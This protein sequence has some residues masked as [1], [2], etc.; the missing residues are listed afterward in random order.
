MKRI[1]ALFLVLFI[2]LAV[3]AHADIIP[4]DMKPIYV[5]AHI[6]N[7]DDYPDYVFVQFES[8]GDEM[9]GAKEIKSSRGIVPGYKLS[10]L[11]VLAVPR[12]LFE[13]QGGIAGLNLMDDSRI[14][15]SGPTGIRGQELVERNSSL[16]GRDVFYRVSVDN[17]GVSLKQTG[18][19]EFFE[20]PNS[21]AVDLMFY[22]LVITFS[23]ELIVFILLMRIGFRSRV[24]AVGRILFAVLAAQLATLP[25]LWLIISYYSLVGTVVMLT[26]EAFAVGVETVVYRFLAR[27]SWKRALIAAAVCNGMSYLVG[28]MA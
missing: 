6:E 8:L 23:V 13:E 21:V 16:A 11:E 4:K 9:R 26:A 18:Q 12:D 24:P 10:T 5:S 28:M 17:D 25:L 1:S 15:R 22:G 7:L 14:V 27:L 19:K 20:E 2:L 3:P